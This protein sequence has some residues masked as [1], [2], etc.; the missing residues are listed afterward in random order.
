MLQTPLLCEAPQPHP[1]VISGGNGTLSP[2]S[3]QSFQGSI[4]YSH[5][6]ALLPFQ[7]V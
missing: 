4:T 7:T 2:G 3:N 6:Q 5:F 1:H